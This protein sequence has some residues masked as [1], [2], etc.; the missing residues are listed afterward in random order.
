V[1]TSLKTTLRLVGPVRAPR[2]VFDVE[3]LRTEFKTALVQAGKRELVARLDAAIGDKLPEGVPSVDQ[4]TQ[5]PLKAGQQAIQGVL[6][7]QRK[8]DEEKKK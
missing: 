1:L 2:L 7:G 3:G 8:A 6:G 4:V 5:D